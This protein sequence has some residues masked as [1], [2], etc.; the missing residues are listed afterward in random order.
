[1]Q[2]DEL[3]MSIARAIAAANDE[4]VRSGIDDAGSLVTLSEEA[5]PPDRVWQVHYGP[6]DFS[7]C[8][9]GDFMVSVAAQTGDIRRV[10]RGQ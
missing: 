3:A 2:H 10:Q 8:R 1:M 5:P 7:N 6:R 4:A 9:D